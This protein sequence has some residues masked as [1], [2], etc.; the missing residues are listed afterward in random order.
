M[1]SPTASPEVATLGAFLGATP[2][3]PAGPARPWTPA[4][5]PPA[6]SLLADN[7]RR[8]AAGV[9]ST[10]SASRP[11]TAAQHVQAVLSATRG[12]FSAPPTPRTSLDQVVGDR[13]QPGRHPRQPRTGQAG[14][15]PA[16]REGQRRPAGGDRSRP[17]GAPARPRRTR[18][19]PRPA[20]LRSRDA[21]AGPTPR[22]GT[23][24]I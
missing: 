5:V 11:L 23:R 6:R 19:G 17:A 18:R 12:M 7:L 15:A 14:R 10:F 3:T 2:G 1:P 4:P 9:G 20:G 8:Q 16:R 24:G 22:A 13:P 21:A